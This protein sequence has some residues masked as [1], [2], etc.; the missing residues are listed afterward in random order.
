MLAVVDGRAVHR[1]EPQPTLAVFDDADRKGCDQAVGGAVG[2]P[3]S[4]AH[5]GAGRDGLA[6]WGRRA[7]EF[8]RDAGGFF[9]RCPELGIQHLQG[10]GI[11]DLGKVL[12]RSELEEA[13]K[14]A[15]D[16]SA[17][18]FSRG[19]EALLGE[20]GGDLLFVDRFEGGAALGR[21]PEGEAGEG[22][23]RVLCS[24]GL[25]AEDGRIEYQDD[26]E[27]DHDL[28]PAIDK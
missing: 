5:A 8:E 22:R 13:G 2:L 15:V 28:L 1:P 11:G 24:G 17:A 3:R 25:P 14:D 26:R 6:G 10:E 4:P 12:L 18:F 20:E 21:H 19:E 23:R 7:V 27:S 16:G 9:G